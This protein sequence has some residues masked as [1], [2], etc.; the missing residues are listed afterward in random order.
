LINNLS[1]VIKNLFKLMK[2]YTVVT[3]GTSFVDLNLSY[4]KWLKINYQNDIK[5][6]F[7]LER[8]IK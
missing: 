3:A 2:D 5:N 8:Q 4:L 1:I 7:D 6:L